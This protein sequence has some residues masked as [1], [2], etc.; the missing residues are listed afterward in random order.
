MQTRNNYGP[1]ALAL[2][3]LWVRASSAFAQEPCDDVQP[4]SCVT[5]HDNAGAAHQAVYDELYQDGVITV[6]DMAYEYSA[7]NTHV[8]TFTMTKEGEPF[9]P[10]DADRVRMYFVP[11]TGSA[12]QYEPAADRLALTGTLT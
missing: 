4:E 8:V 12:F 3:V 9:D 5:C 11:Y 6:T 10:A 1:V 2:Y 7:P